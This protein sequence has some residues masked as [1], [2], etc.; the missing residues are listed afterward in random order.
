MLPS[1]REDSEARGFAGFES[2]TASAELDTSPYEGGAGCRPLSW[3][4]ERLCESPRALFLLLFRHLDEVLGFS[5]LLSSIDFRGEANSAVLF[6]EEARL[7]SEGLT[8]RC[9]S[10]CWTSAVPSLVVGA[11]LTIDGSTTS[12]EGGGIGGTSS[13]VLLPSIFA[14]VA[15]WDSEKLRKRIRLVRLPLWRAAF[16]CRKW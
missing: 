2:G 7:N 9:S 5:A 16:H 12:A 11:V 14:L 4:V 15:R 8:T 6:R 13:S 3:I 10:T 1:D